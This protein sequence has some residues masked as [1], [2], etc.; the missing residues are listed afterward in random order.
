M[1]SY[2]MKEKNKTIY[3]IETDDPQKV[4]AMGLDA[5]LRTRDTGKEHKVVEHVEPV[6]EIDEE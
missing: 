3:T 4:Y 1:K 2:H 5:E 6:E